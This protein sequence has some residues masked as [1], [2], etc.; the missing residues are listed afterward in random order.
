[1]SEISR[2]VQIVKQAKKNVDCT[3]YSPYVAGMLTWQGRTMMWQ[4]LSWQGCTSWQVTVG[5]WMWS[6]HFLTRGILVANGLVT[7]GPSKGCHVSPG[8]WLKFV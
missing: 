1:M 8:Q 6:N 5:S 3:V 2:S 4:M 7:R